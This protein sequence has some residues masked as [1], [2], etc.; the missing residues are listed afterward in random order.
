MNLKPE[1][2]ATLVALGTTNDELT[3][4][5]N[6]MLGAVSGLQ[7][8]LNALDAQLQVLNAQRDA[9]VAELTQ[10]NI[11]VAKLIDPEV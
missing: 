4:L 6:R 5:S 11:T 3:L 8:Q 10:A 9:V 7:A 1:L 2:L